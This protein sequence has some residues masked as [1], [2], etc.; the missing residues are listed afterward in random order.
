MTVYA[1]G[2]LETD[3]KKQNMALQ[4][5]AAAINAAETDIASLQTSVATNTANT[6]T[7]T[8]NIT[9]LT[10]GHLFGLTL[11]TVGSSATFSVAAGSA[12]DS[13]GT[14]V[15]AL[16]SAISKTTSSWAVGTGNGALDTGSV[17]NSTWYHVFLIKRTDTDVEDVLI[18]TSASAPT[19]PASYTLK[20][21][22]GSMLTNGSAQWV[23]F[24]QL[25]DEFLW[26]TIVNNA[27]A[28]NP[29]TSGTLYTLTVPT[30][31]QVLAQLSILWFNVTSS[32]YLFV[33]SPDITAPTV[34]TATN[35]TLYSVDSTHP[36]VTGAY[37]RTDTSG[38]VRATSN[39]SN[40][41]MYINTVGW[42][43]R[44]GRDV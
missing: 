11:S 41:S 39:G 35:A 24:V 6:A 40:G 16:A 26:D 21:R 15:M 36:G 37:V 9:N 34:T 1:P 4:Q 17:A 44:R 38:R 22:I 13:A 23:K 8:T 10:P 12:A 28:Q 5:Y 29:G 27:N 14:A 19:M 30:G 33:S 2:T 42:V 20:R 18:S 7:N 25:G 43:D 32:N 31:V 3:Q